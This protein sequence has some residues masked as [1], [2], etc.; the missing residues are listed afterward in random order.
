M[1][2]VTQPGTARFN[3]GRGAVTRSSYD[4]GGG[5]M[6]LRL[7][8]REAAPGAESSVTGRPG[9]SAACACASP[10]TITAGGSFMLDVQCYAGFLYK[11]V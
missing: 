8:C 10:C 7:P 1:L 9:A 11:P 5:T 3:G 2:K 4:A 6:A